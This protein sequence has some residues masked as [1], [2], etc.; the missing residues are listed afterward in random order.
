MSHKFKPVDN[1]TISLASPR[2][3]EII[4]AY[5]EHKSTRKAGKALGISKTAVANAVT[6]AIKSVAPLRGY[7]PDH[8]MI[9]ATPPTHIVKGTSTLYDKDGELRLQWV[10]TKLSD[11]HLEQML[12]A[13]AKEVSES[14]KRVKPRA[15]PKHKFNDQ[16]ATCYMIGDGHLGLK[17]KEIETGIED[18]DLERSVFDH[19]NSLNYLIGRA[20]K[21]EVGVFVNVG[22]LLH[23]NDDKNMTPASGHSLDAEERIQVTGRKASKLLRNGIDAAL[24]KHKEVWVVNARGNHDNDPAQWINIILETAYE[25][26]P[27]V[28]IIN[29][30]TKLC[31]FTFGKN[32]VVVYHGDRVKPDRVYERITSGEFRAMHGAANYTHCWSGHIH[33]ESVKIIGGARFET[34]NSLIPAD[35][36][37][38][39]M[40]YNAA[41]SMSAITLH[42]EFGEVGRDTCSIDLV[43]SI[44]GQYSSVA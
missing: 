37:A 21:T 40:M 24:M 1:Q 14:V 18:F 43:R 17:T 8:D 42:S 27:R 31:H 35:R 41:R 36:H 15:V 25:N 16:I 6:R 28:K 26:E 38:A 12:E 7:S 44:Y 20:D 19:S 3:Q 13:Y 5:N 29:N 32:L 23:C 9:H 33:H 11:E 2:Q 39:D 22:D 4:K 10:K 30:A 34:F